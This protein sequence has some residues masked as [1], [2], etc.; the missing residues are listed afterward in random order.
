MNAAKL[1]RNLFLN[2]LWIKIKKKIIIV[3]LFNKWYYYIMHR[4]VFNQMK[5]SVS[6]HSTSRGN[7]VS[8]TETRTNFLR[9]SL[10]LIRV[11][12]PPERTLMRERGGRTNVESEMK[13][14][15]VNG[16]KVLP[17]GGKWA[18]S[19]RARLSPLRPRVRSTFQ[20]N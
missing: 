16:P 7:R 14:N 10:V 8:R 12:E 4:D 11:S 13:M 2:S 1:G 18:T 20:D 3:N 19:T 15:W 5:R 9:K 6:V 17:S